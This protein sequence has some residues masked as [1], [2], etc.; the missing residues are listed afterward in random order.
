MD[1]HIILTVEEARDLLDLLWVSYDVAL[2]GN[3]IVEAMR[4]MVWIEEIERRLY[5]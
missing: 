5:G 3:Q 4:L 1:E 2:T